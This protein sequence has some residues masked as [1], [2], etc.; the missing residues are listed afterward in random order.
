VG[1][2]DHD[3][4]LIGITYQLRPT[5]EVT[6]KF[7][8][9]FDKRVIRMITTNFEEIGSRQYKFTPEQVTDQWLDDLGNFILRKH[10]KLHTL[11]L[12]LSMR[13]EIKERLSDEMNSR[14]QELKDIELREQLE[15]NSGQTK[16]GI[17]DKLKSLTNNF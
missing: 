16:A 5:V 6:L 7:V 1:V 15:Q 9:D 3:Q 11:D 10:A 12:P 2:R 13:D 4:N 14:D 8:V 17:L